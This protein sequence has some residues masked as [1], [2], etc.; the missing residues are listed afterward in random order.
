MTL[1]GKGWTLDVTRDMIDATPISEPDPNWLYVDPSGHEHRYGKDFETPTLG[2]VST[3]WYWC[4]LCCEAHESGNWRCLRC[5]A[6]VVAGTRAVVIRQYVAGL[7]HVHGTIIEGV[8]GFGELVA[9]F[10]TD[11][12][13]DLR[14]GDVLVRSARPV[15]LVDTLNP[16]IRDASARIEFTAERVEAAS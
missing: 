11:D 6:V 3:G 7:T 15:E 13:V 1:Q 5:G 8:A 4:D 16:H 10:E 2:W 14:L 9:A 12:T